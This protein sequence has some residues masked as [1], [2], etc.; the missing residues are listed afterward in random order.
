[1][2]RRPSRSTLFHYTTH[3][4]SLFSDFLHYPK[5][6]LF[7]FQ[8]IAHSST[9]NTGGGVPPSS[10]A[11]PLGPDHWEASIDRRQS[12]GGTAWPKSRKISTGHYSYRRTGHR[13]LTTDHC[14]TLPRRPCE[15]S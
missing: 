9:K 11:M 5:S 2:I 14:L 6:Q 1:M 7:S 4:R 12:T 10:F 8:P 15:T 3:F 13:K